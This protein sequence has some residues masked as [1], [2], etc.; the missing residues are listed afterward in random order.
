[1]VRS[2]IRALLKAAAE[3]L[4]AELRSV[5]KRDDDYAS[6]GKPACDWEDEAAREA[7]VDALARDAYAVLAQLDARALSTDVRQ[8]AELV[9]TVV[10]QDLEQRDDGVF[11]IAHR[12]APDRVISTVDPEA[13]HGH[14][15][16]ARGFD[17]YKGH[18]AIDPDSELITRTAV[19]AGNAGDASV[20]QALLVDVLDASANE[21]GLDETSQV[22]S[23][24]DVAPATSSTA[25][26]E[27]SKAEVYGDASYGTADL[28]E[29]LEGANVEANVK[30]QP[31]SARAGMFSQ[32]AFE[33]DTSAGTACCPNGVRVRLRVLP[34][35]SRTADFA[36]NCVG[37]SLRQQCTT[38]KR[39]R[40]LRLH[41]K[42]ETLTRAREAQRDPSWKQRYR[43]TRPKVERKIAHLMR[44]RHG[45]RRAR[46]RGRVRIGHDFALL[47]AAV[48]LY[49]LAALGAPVQA[50]RGI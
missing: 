26:C 37:C 9:A 2:S 11:R 4:A 44:T 48:N 42:H 16:S 36:S 7:L 8:A 50:C 1:M 29:R 20:T 14:K 31:P 15:T 25:A 12:V 45:G 33:I 27:P 47:A 32:D 28:V 21:T 22:S 46:V 35:N 43:A 13:R 3:P 38:S 39:G 30:V 10:G 23:S 40:V 34:D 19:S 49:H 6:A 5:L 24:T 17:G 41:P 18:V